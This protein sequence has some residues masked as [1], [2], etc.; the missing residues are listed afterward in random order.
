M[1]LIFTASQTVGPFFSI[2]LSGLCRQTSTPESALSSAI[3]IA[4]KLLDGDQKP[5]P[6]AVFE[7]WARGQ[8]ARTATN[9]DGSFAVN[10]RRPAD[11]HHF[12]VL[13]FMRG[14]LRPVLTRVY[15]R[16]A[17]A[18]GSDE[19]FMQIPQERRATLIAQQ[20]KAGGHFAWDVHM[21]GENETVFFDF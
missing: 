3:T 9:D 19:C 20:G 15:F 12:E 1:K 14:L 7:F 6:D 16:E 18:L 10:L 11:A 2:G 4:G 17:K 21:Q 8:F 5:I 13:I